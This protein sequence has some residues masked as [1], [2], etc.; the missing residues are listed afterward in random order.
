MANCVYSSK[1]LERSKKNRYLTMQLWWG[2]QIRFYSWFNRWWICTIPSSR[3]KEGTE[4]WHFRSGHLFCRSDKENNWECQQ[5][6]ETSISFRNSSN[7]LR[8]QDT[9]FIWLN[10]YSILISIFCYI[11]IFNYILMCRYFTIFR[12]QVIKRIY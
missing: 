6:G 2:L 9:N 5:N 10:K 11:L 7:N 3:T 4:T 1:L 8:R 12:R